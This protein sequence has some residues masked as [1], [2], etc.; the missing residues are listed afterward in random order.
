M[1]SNQA[2]QIQDFL[3]ATAGTASIDWTTGSDNWGWMG[4]VVKEE[5]AGGGGGTGLFNTLLGVG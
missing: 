2:V 4:I 1:E 5:G 3:Q